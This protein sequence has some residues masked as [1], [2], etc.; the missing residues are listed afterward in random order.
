MVV[1][2]VGIKFSWIS[3]SFLS[4]IIYVICGVSCIIFVALGFEIVEY[5]FVSVTSCYTSLSLH[6]ISITLLN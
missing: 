5:Q 4:M 1:N 2:F 6:L 3:L